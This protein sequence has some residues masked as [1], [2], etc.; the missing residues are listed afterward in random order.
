MADSAT[1]EHPFGALVRFFVDE[2]TIGDTLLRVA[3]LACLAGPADMAGITMS[4]Q[5]KLETGVFT[6]TEA[7][8]IDQAQYSTGQ[9]PCVDAFRRLQVYRIEST[10]TDTRWPDF[11]ADAA[12]HGIMSTHSLPI[13]ARGQGSGCAQPLLAARRLHSVTRTSRG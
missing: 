10:D 2:S 11:A 13:V 3:E 6:H 4:V 12:A 8:E 5:N 7:P 9:G 1:A